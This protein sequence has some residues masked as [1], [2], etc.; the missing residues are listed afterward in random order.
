MNADILKNIA[1]TYGTPSYIFN[2]D[3]LESRLNT[4][5]QILGEG[6]DVLYAMKANPFLVPVMS[7]LGMRFEVCSPGEFAICE[8]EHVNMQDIVLSGVNKERADIE[9]VM[10]DCGG[11][12]IYTV[13]SVRH[14]QLLASMAEKRSTVIHVL[15]R[16]TSGNQFGLDE[17]DI[18]NIISKRDEFKYVD[19]RGI[20]CYTG[21]QKK[22]SDHIDKEIDWLDSLCDRLYEKYGYKAEEFEYG[23]GLFVAYFEPGVDNNNYDMLRALAAKLDTIRDKY[24][25]SLEMG[26]YIAATC[27]LFLTRVEDIKYNKEQHYCIVDG[28]INHINYYGQT[29]AMKLPVTEHIPM[30]VDASKTFAM[31]DACALL[32]NELVRKSEGTVHWNVCG[33][34]CTV[35]DVIVKNLELTDLK[36]GD[37]LVFHNIGAYSVTEGIYLFLSRNLPNIIE[38]SSKN[39]ARLLRGQNPTY[40][41]NSQIHN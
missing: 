39:G 17:E 26:R 36:I 22:K 18:E 37:M 32:G 8:N 28:G 40:V 19:I 21:T 13:E 41:I 34:L 31:S 9:H 30:D 4:I 10:D 35:G 11:V 14:F 24:H 33:S 29:M 20:Q 2:V 6:I 27:G 12:G 16:V 25:I 1:H 5:K 23:P 3:E 15:L 7:R 38:Y